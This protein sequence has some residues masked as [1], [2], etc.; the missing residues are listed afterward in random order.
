M[1]KVRALREMVPVFLQHGKE[2][3]MCRAS[4]G[5]HS[6]NGSVTIARRENCSDMTPACSCWT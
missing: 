1:F 6:G 5:S 3:R 4:T 2:V